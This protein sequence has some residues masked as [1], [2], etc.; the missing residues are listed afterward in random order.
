[1]LASNKYLI[2][3]RNILRNQR[4]MR[5]CNPGLPRLSVQLGGIPE[6]YREVRVEKERK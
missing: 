6:S 1:M 2:Y 4:S 5:A 3:N